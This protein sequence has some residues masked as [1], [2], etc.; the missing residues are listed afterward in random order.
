MFSQAITWHKVKQIVTAQQEITGAR[1]VHEFPPVITG[2]FGP[3]CPGDPGI[4]ISLRKS[5]FPNQGPEDT[6]VLHTCMTRDDRTTIVC[7][8]RVSLSNLGSAGEFVF[9]Y[10]VPARSSSLTK[11]GP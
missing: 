6:S 3:F 9:L 10:L 4:Y 11:I 1:I 2:Y 5:V 8:I 7:W